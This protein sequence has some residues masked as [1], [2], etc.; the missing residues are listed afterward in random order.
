MI[1]SKEKIAAER[2]RKAEYQ[3][4]R[5]HLMM[6][7]KDEDTADADRVHAIELVMT[8]DREGVPPV[9]AY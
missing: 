6:M 7:I 5:S 8:L 4:M 1:T 3:E 9:Y 2:A